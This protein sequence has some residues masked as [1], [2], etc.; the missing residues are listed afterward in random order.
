MNARTVSTLSSDTVVH[1]VRIA[2]K[3]VEMANARAS[4][5]VQRHFES[6]ADGGL[7]EAAKLWHP[8]I[9]W[10]AVEGALDDVGVIRGRDAMRRYYAEWVDTM[11]DLRASVEVVFE[12]GDVVAA[13][14]RNSGRGRAS[15]V[16]AAGTY[17]VACLV[18]D[19]LL[20]AG[21]EYASRE[22]AVAAAQRLLAAG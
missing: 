15:G 6:F 9:E 11:E 16:P 14:I 8:E 5:V 10:R 13:L 4:E 20:V 19:G 12:D 3:T 18:R 1:F 17:Y 7:E 21:H 22:E 2:S